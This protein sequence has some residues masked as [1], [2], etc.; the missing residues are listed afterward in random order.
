MN[1]KIK[2]VLSLTLIASLLAGGAAA[3]LPTGTVSADTL[4][5]RGGPGGSQ[6]QGMGG[7]MSG[8]GL[9]LTPLT[10]IEADALQQAILE[11]YGALNLY[12][13]VIAQFGSSLPFSQ[14]ARSEQMHV[15]ALIRQADKYDV[16]VSRQ[17]WSDKHD[18][19]RLVVGCLS[20]RRVSRDRRR[21][22]L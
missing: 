6:G 11:E 21:G 3:F 19:I 12:N 13:A 5:G 14:I 1:T 22:S 8:S 16:D 9:A 2:I 20:G 15:N 17:S 7:G 10:T 18:Q 4:D